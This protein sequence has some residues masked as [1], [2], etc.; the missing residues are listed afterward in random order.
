MNHFRK[1]VLVTC[2]CVGAV[3][4]AKAEKPNILLI[5]TDDQARETVGYAGLNSQVKT[6]NMD[7]LARDGVWFEKSYATTSICMASRAIIMHG[8]YEY[9][10][11]CN[12]QHG[13]ITKEK[14]AQSYPMLLK[15]AGYYVGFAGK[16]GFGVNEDGQGTAHHKYENLPVDSFDWWG[17]GIGQT[18][19]QTAKNKY[20]AKYAETYP[21]SSRAYGAAAG[22]FFEEAQK[23]GKP[24]C[25][26]ISFKAPHLPFEPDPMFDDIYADTVWKKPANYGKGAAEHFSAQA[27]LGRQYNEISDKWEEPNYQESMRLYNQLIYGVDYSIGMIRKKLEELGL[28]DNTVIIFTSDNGYSIGRHGMGGKVLPY[29]EASAVPMVVFDPRSPT[30]FKGARTRSLSAGVDI[31]PTILALAGLPI[32]EHMDGVSLVPNTQNPA[33]PT[34]EFLPLM[35]VWGKKHTLVH[36][37]VSDSWKYIYYPY[38][39]RMPVGEEL[40]YLRNDPREMKNQI[41]NPEYAGI[42]KQI[43]EQYDVSVE[44]WKAEAVPYNGYRCYGRIFDRHLEWDEKKAFYAKPKKK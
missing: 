44:K 10:T 2:L 18:V 25:L 32:P 29:E 38:A 26:S 42:L 9:K 37:M 20:I 8:M 35:Q 33:A 30:A 4:H 21:H 1:T 19:F 28:A 14:F 23:S 3:C 34:R 6:P 17:G 27:K 41:N 36:S 43:R 39:D 16:F 7:Q 11:G 31:A 15:D 22:D 13:S 5:L 40:Y 12:F 24:F